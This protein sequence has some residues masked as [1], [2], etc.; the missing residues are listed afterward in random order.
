MLPDDAEK[1]PI[2][3]HTTGKQQDVVAYL[4][5]AQTFD[6]LSGAPV[7]QREM[8]SL[9]NTFVTHNGGPAIVATGA[10]LLG[11]YSGAWEGPPSDEL[12]KARGWRPDT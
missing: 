8:V 11:V 5:E 6:G 3:N 7:F 12:A 2:K 1:L 4:V 10:Q 9:A